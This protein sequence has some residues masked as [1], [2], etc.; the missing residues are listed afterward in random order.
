[1]RNLDAKKLLFVGFGQIAEKCVQ[2]FQQSGAE[3]YAI[4]RR[5]RDIAGVTYW[6]GD[7]RSFE[8]L[9]RIA[10]E[11][12]DSIIITLSPDEYTAHAYESTYLHSVNALLGLWPKGR[13]SS[14]RIIFISSTSVYHQN[15]GEWVDENSPTNPVSDTAKILLATEQLVRDYDGCGIVLRFSGIYGPGRDYLLRQVW[16]GEGGSE[17]YTNRVHIDD[18]VGSIVHVVGLHDHECESIYLVSDKTPVKSQD[19]RRWLAAE[20]GK[21]PDSLS[22]TASA[23]QRGGNKLCNAGR[24]EA[25][26]FR[27]I[28][29]DFREGYQEAI[30]Q[31]LKDVKGQAA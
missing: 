11:N 26:G 30:R 17:Q 10:K 5:K 25:S 15:D 16:K 22:M 14:P 9:G 29:P 7:I 8:V 23:S 13:A 28:Y 24:I 6:Q 3:I 21:D 20:L 2:E 12:F 1:M 4:G 19:I 18:C 31:F 27:F